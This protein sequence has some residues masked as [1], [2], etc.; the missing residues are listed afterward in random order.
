M[1]RPQRPPLVR[2]LTIKHMMVSKARG[3]FAG[4]TASSAQPM[5]AVRPG[6]PVGPV[7]RTVPG[8]ISLYR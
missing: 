8:L 5:V 3:R 6:P 7:V 4:F 2:G 1:A